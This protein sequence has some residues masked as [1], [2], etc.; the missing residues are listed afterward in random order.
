MSSR[1][2]QQT[3][4]NRSA[5]WRSSAES[6][7]PESATQLKQ[8]R[9]HTEDEIEVAIQAS[10]SAALEELEQLELG[11]TPPR[12]SQ[13]MRIPHGMPPLP[14]GRVMPPLPFARVLSLRPRKP[15]A[16]PP[17]ATDDVPLLPVRQ[18]EPDLLL[19]RWPGVVAGVLGVLLVGA[20]IWLSLVQ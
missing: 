10:L 5:A 7:L 2:H 19:Q 11:P 14:G 15:T 8:A 17:R 16:P 6:G 13:K 18:Q 4:A 3:S 1:R 9:T 12:P 20:A